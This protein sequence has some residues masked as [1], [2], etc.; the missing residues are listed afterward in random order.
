[1]NCDNGTTHNVSISIQQKLENTLVFPS[2]P[3]K[4][5]IN[6][7]QK[8]RKTS[9]IKDKFMKD[10]AHPLS[11]QSINHN[12]KYTTFSYICCFNDMPGMPYSYLCI[13]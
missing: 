12:Y 6:E 5:I 8:E 7:E 4:N 10:Q 2:N 1:M 13:Y 11:K 3:P 9:T